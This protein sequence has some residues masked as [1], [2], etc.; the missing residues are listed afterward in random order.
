MKVLVIVLVSFLVVLLSKYSAQVNLFQSLDFARDALMQFSRGETRVVQVKSPVEDKEETTI[1]PLL[2]RP[3]KTVVTGSGW[4]SKRK[5]KVISPNPRPKPTKPRITYKRKTKVYRPRSS[6][7]NHFLTALNEIERAMAEANA[8]GRRQR[9]SQAQLN[10]LKS[11]IVLGTRHRNYQFAWR[12]VGQALHLLQQKGA[13]RRR[14]KRSSQNAATGFLNDLKNQM[15]SDEFNTFMAVQGDVTLMFA[16]DTTGS[17]EDEIENAKKIAIDVVN[18]KRNNP[19]N[20]ILSPFNDPGIGP[21]KYHD[22]GDGAGFA[23]AIQALPATG[24]GDC[25]ELTFQAMRDALYESPRWGS[26]MYVFTDATA[27]D[28]TTDNIDEVEYLAGEYGVTINFFTTGTCNVGNKPDHFKDLAEKTSGQIIRLTNE[29]ELKQLSG[30]TGS[31]LGG[32]NTISVGSNGSRR[33]K[34]SASGNKHSIVLDDSIEDVTFSITTENPNQPSSLKDPNNVVITSGKVALSKVH[35]YQIENPT[36]GTW[37]LTIPST[38]GKSDFFVKGSS[39]TNIDFEHSFLMRRTRGRAVEDVPISHPVIGKSTQVLIT[40]AGAEKVRPRS[41][42][43]E[44]ITKYGN[45]ISSH[46]LQSRGRRNVHYTST[47][48]APSQ[49]FRL[50]LLGTTKAGNAFERISRNI[51]TPKTVLLRVV[52]SRNQFT[53]PIGRTSFVLFEIINGLRTRETFAIKAKSR[54]GYILPMSRRI[55]A[56]RGGYRS[57]FSLRFRSTKRSDVGKTDIVMVSIKGRGSKAKSVQI[58][59]LLVVNS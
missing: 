9:F 16:I 25:P 29:G 46:S 21:I 28:D 3:N 44:F 12:A 57:H 18:Y 2:V 49:S 10:K 56:V 47:F 51:V 13:D 20:Y 52:H 30:L 50:K 48:S 1:Q 39:A 14:G 15:G 35:V 37:V 42:R 33:K 59:Q 55:K 38:A 27:K 24:G 11:Y 34:R 32:S 8:A 5:P 7:S 23:K 6:P 45:L 54:L 58:V 19:V 41:L 53:L 40:V 22:Y 43:L 36:V 4:W 26:P 31:V 17:M